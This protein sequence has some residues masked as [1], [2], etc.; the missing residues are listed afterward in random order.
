M[1]DVSVDKMITIL[2]NNVIEPKVKEEAMSQARSQTSN[3]SEYSCR[4]SVISQAATIKS[5]GVSFK[6][7]PIKNQF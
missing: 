6:V 1:P 3:R 2:Y 7:H 4:L 5:G